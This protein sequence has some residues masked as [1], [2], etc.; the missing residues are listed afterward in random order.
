[1]KRGILTGSTTI[2]LG[3]LLTVYWVVTPGMQLMVAG[4]SGAMLA[5]GTLLLVYFMRVRVY[6]CN[7]KC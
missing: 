6:Q 5:A 7:D 4:I 1:M 3:V 2:L